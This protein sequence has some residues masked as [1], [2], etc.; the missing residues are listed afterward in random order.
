MT[1]LTLH[2]LDTSRSHR[3][4]WLLEELGL[5][6]EL[7][8]HTREPRTKRAPASLRAVHPLGKSP[9]LVVDGVPIA[10]SGA[11]VEHVVD[12]AGGALRPAPGTPEHVRY[13]YWL[14]YAEGSLMPP[15]VIKLICAQVKKAPVPFPLNMIPKAVAGQVDKAFTDPELRLHADWLERHFGAHT[16]A[17]GDTFSAADVQL[18]FP[19]EGLLSHRAIASTIPSVRAWVE[20]LRARPAYERALAKGGPPIGG[21]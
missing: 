14:H 17:T 7:V 8:T 9:V 20:R 2:H 4:L 10:E 13:R 11:I 5:P 12:L 19:A 21:W 15:L 16:Y 3:I 1:T 18:A 6:Y